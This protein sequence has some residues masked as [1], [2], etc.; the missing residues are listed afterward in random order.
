VILI[1][2]SCI[3]DIDVRMWCRGFCTGT[4]QRCIGI[5][6]CSVIPGA[7][8]VCR[9]L[10]LPCYRNFGS[11]ECFKKQWR[12]SYFRLST[13][14]FVLNY[15]NGRF[16]SYSLLLG[17]ISTLNYQNDHF[18]PQIFLVG[19]ISTP[20]YRSGYRVLKLFI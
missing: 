2:N 13:I 4:M 16:S 3:H 11:M 1:Q 17:S 15:K 8:I 9:P 7:H 18:N 5:C 20:D 19:L 10:I 12:N 14:D 6:S